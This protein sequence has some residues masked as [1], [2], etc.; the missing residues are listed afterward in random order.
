[1]TLIDART[2]SVPAPRRT[3]Q[4]MFVPTDFLMVLMV[5]IWGLNFPVVKYGSRVMPALAYNGVRIALA[6][7][8]LLGVAYFTV[9]SRPSRRDILLLLGLGVLGNGVYQLL[10]LGSVVNTDVGI[11]AILLATS[12]AFIA[13]FSRFF[14]LGVISRRCALGIV[15]SLAGVAMIALTSRVAANGSSSVLGNMLAV[16]AAILWALYAVL[17]ARYVT[18]VDDIT[19]AA[20]TLTG[21]AVPLLLAGLPGI[22][23]TSWTRLPAGAWMAIAF[24]GLVSLA[25]ASVFW[26]RGIRILGATRTGIYLNLEPV[27][28]LL[29]AWIWFH[30]FP[31]RWQGVGAATILAG[32][33]LTRT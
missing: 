25:L 16:L 18:E 5:A 13:L 4:P 33:T 8:I 26:Y 23:R 2:V 17:Q 30:Q 32:V 22:L 7:I 12:P 15:L 31:T 20:L 3:A 10:F 1:M 6:A 21:G 19:V 28:A 14:G 11:A 24:S 9:R 27:F 29:A